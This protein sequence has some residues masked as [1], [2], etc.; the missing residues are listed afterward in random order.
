MIVKDNA[1][2][3]EMANF[4]NDGHPEYQD[5]AK[6]WELVEEADRE[7][8][9]GPGG[10]ARDDEG[11]GKP[12][13]GALPKGLL[14]ENEPEETGG[15]GPEP[16]PAPQPSKPIPQRREIPSLSRKYI[17]QKSNV[18]WN[19]TAFEVEAGDADLPKGAPWAMPLADV[20]TRNYHFLY[21][22]NPEV[23]RSITMTPRDGL[24]SHLAWMTGE[25]LRTSK[26]TPQLGVILA[27]L[28]ANYGDDTLLDSKTMSPDASAIRGDRRHRE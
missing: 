21:D 23:F 18:S 25:L 19:V 22:P 5:D 9:Y 17:Y 7:L 12:G 14:D 28:R 2:A 16:D 26:E 20:A 3:I 24:L 11:S 10:K 8:L 6:W 4:F 15:K 27:E 13:G 1:R